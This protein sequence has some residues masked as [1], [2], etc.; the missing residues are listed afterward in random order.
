MLQKIEA[1]KENLRERNIL[2]QWRNTATKHKS[3]HPVGVQIHTVLSHETTTLQLAVNQQTQKGELNV[4]KE[5]H[6]LTIFNSVLLTL[7]LA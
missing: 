2:G 3:L 5:T 4:P 6:S 1:K 7:F